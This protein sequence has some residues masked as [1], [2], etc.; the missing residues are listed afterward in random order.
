MHEK[1]SETSEDKMHE[2]DSE[3]SVNKM[4]EKNS[5]TSENST[6]SREDGRW[7]IEGREM[8]D[9]RW[10]M[11]EVATPTESRSQGLLEPAGRRPARQPDNWD[12]L[13]MVA[14]AWK[15][16]AHDDQGGA[17]PTSGDLM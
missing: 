4:H 11:G 8:G 6:T 17:R 15:E 9:G 14:G 13:Q 12:N 7:K 1:D 10:K 16:M 5:E 2:K 3:Y